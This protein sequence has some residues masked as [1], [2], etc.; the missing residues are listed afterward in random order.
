MIKERDYETKKLPKKLKNTF[1][2]L[3]KLLKK[4]KKTF[5]I[6]KKLMKTFN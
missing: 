1:K 6:L 2:N 5:E 3:T 4:F